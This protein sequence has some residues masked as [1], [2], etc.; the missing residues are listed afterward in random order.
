MNQKFLFGFV[1]AASLGIA[2]G[3]A[4]AWVHFSYPSAEV[5]TPNEEDI[6]S[7]YSSTSTASD[8]RMDPLVADVP[9]ENFIENPLPHPTTPEPKPTAPT[10]TPEPVS[11]G[12]EISEARCAQLLAA[13]PFYADPVRQSVRSEKELMKNGR[14]DEAALLR[15]VTCYPVAVWL[16]GRPYT[17]TTA[18]IKRTTSEA[19]QSGKIVVFAVYNV[20]D[21][22]SATWHSAL[23]NG[24]YGAWIEVVAEAI[25]PSRAWLILEPDALPMSMSLSEL[26]RTKRISE[27]K[28]AVELLRTKAPNTRVYLD[29]GHSHWL[30][31]DEAATLLDRAGIETAHGFSL[32]VSNYQATEVVKNYGK[33][34]SNKVAG[35]SFIIDTARNGNGAA[36]DNEWCNAKGRALG[37]TSQMEESDPQVDAYLWIKPPGESDGTCNG[38]PTPGVFWLEY[39]LDL[40]RNRR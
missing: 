5:V 21:H 18:T 13:N 35:K 14:T 6:P 39:A 16:S 31:P 40:V 30:T 2:L 20:P 37:I 4:Y 22:H 29:I 8:P 28:A 11:D 3:A 33:Q 34:I 25:G 23:P 9:T 15:N 36:P 19:A 12:D 1:F 32:N 26:D 17:E 10:P 38:G 24:D 27:I 7:S